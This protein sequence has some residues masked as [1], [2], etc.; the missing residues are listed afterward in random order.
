MQPISLDGKN[1][2]T[3]QKMGDKVIDAGAFEKTCI[4]FINQGNYI[5]RVTILNG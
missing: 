5:N 1:N 3:G 2:R 4:E